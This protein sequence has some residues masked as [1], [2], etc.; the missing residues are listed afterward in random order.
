MHPPDPLLL[1]AFYRMHASV[2]IPIETEREATGYAK[3]S[4]RWM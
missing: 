3:I 2:P 1:Q 4:V